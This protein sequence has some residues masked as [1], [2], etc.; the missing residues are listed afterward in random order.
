ML[1]PTPPERLV[2]QN[3]RPTFLWD[4]DL[5]LDELKQRLEDEDPEIRAYWIGTVMRQ[6]RPDDALQLVPAAQMRAAWPKLVRTLG[7]ERAFWAWLLP[8]LEKRGQ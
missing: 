5:T 4:C 2:D 7:R 1:N 3:G 8:E 6:A